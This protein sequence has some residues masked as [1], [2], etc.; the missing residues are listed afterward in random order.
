MF[1]LYHFSVKN[2]TVRTVPLKLRIYLI[3]PYP[4]ANPN[5]NDPFIN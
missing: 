2:D 1:C 3:K 4:K 5:A